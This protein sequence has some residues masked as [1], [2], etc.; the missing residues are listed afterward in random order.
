MKKEEFDPVKISSRIYEKLKIHHYNLTGFLGYHQDFDLGINETI[1]TFET[2]ISEIERE[3]KGG[4]SEWSDLLSYV[5]ENWKNLSILKTVAENE[6]FIAHNEFLD[7]SAQN[8]PSTDESGYPLFPYYEKEE[9]AQLVDPEKDIGW[10]LFIPN[11]VRDNL[12][13]D[14]HHKLINRQGIHYPETHFGIFFVFFDWRL[15]E[16]RYGG[17]YFATPTEISN[18]ASALDMW[19]SPRFPFN[20]FNWEGDWIGDDA[21][22]TIQ[23]RNGENFHVAGGGFYLG[24]NA[25]ILL[26]LQS[27]KQLGILNWWTSLQE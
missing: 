15:E 13:P 17:W 16:W 27:R 10:F 8:L 19:G 6:S 12:T 7:L 25:E 1:D 5:E 11:S 26:D 18:D 3:T 2:G 21:E 24:P 14:N 23:W 4:N 22:G 20:H 9:F